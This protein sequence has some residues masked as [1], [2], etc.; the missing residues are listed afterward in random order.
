MNVLILFDSTSIKAWLVNEPIEAA[1]GHIR[2]G[3]PDLLP[4]WEDG[5]MKAIVIDVP[6][7]DAFLSDLY[8]VSGDT[9]VRKPAS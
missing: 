4:G 9:V 2:N 8:E 6:A 3:Y 7:E 5:T 1:E